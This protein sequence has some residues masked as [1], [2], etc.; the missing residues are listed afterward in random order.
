MSLIQF[1]DDGDPIVLNTDSVAYIESANNGAACNV[2]FVGVD[3][4]RRFEIPFQDLLAMLD[5]ET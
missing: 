3:N 5:I 1:L 2:F 4:P